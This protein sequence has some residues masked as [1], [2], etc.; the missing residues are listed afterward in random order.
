[1]KI[2]LLS[3]ALLTASSYAALPKEDAYI[4]S[5]RNRFFQA[6]LPLERDLFNKS[7][8][9]IGRKA[10]PGNFEDDFIINELRFY[11]NIGY[12]PFVT[13]TNF[14]LDDHALVEYKSSYVAYYNDGLSEEYLALRVGEQGEL[15]WEAS[16]IN[17]KNIYPNKQVPVMRY[18]EKTVVHAYGICEQF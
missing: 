5:L 13:A 15:L 6:R 7:F 10:L 12:L 11:P 9:C 17:E 16:L 8:E 14:R 2:F 4:R 1:M 3:F 18:P